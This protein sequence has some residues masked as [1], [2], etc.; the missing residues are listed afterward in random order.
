MKEFLSELDKTD[1]RSRITSLKG[2]RFSDLEDINGFQYVDLVQ[3]GGGVL[4][5]ALV[6]YTYVLEEAGIRFISLAGT[7][8]GAINTVMFA[9]L[10]EI[11]D[12]KSESV[13]NL[14]SRKNLLDLVDGSPIIKKL[15]Q[16]FVR[17]KRGRILFLILNAF[18]L[19][20]IIKEKLGINPGR[21][22]QNWI[23]QE[24]E[25]AGVETILDLMN[26]RKRLPSGLRHVGGQE[27]GTVE[28]KT[29][30]I[31][32]EITT[33]TKVEFP[34][35]AE[36]YWSSPDDV[37]LS[38]L[39]RASMSIPFFFEP[40]QVKNVPNDET[41]P[42]PTPNRSYKQLWDDYASY[43]GPIPPAVK[44]VDGGMLSNFPIDVFH[45]TDGK[46]P[47]RPTFGVR[48]STYRGMFSS[49]KD[50]FGFS[51]AMISTMRQIHDYDFLM[52]NPDYRQLIC[53]VDADQEFN[54]LDFEM[55][56]QDQIRLFVK[57]AQKAIEFLEQFDWEAYKRLRAGLLV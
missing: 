4:G 46:M 56:G 40:L 31:T 53:R 51:G 13:L 2:K 39:V 36:M 47:T 27:L 29:A 33:H 18:K 54:W 16:N 48:L 10:G 28:A 24:L 49:I 44:F 23:D 7:S 21:D 45:R 35:M 19:Y 57:G 8:A 50:L 26:L 15:V 42:T 38:E 52:R 3:E 32:S 5:I 43:H 11:N 37:R 22:F 17:K 34:K 20:R 55:S 30:I 41:T 14:I 6:G 9:A 25:K 12:R 1:I